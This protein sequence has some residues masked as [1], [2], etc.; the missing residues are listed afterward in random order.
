MPNPQRITSDWVVT[1]LPAGKG[2]EGFDLSPN[3][4]ELWVA[5]AQDG[6]VS[7]IDPIGRKLLETVTVPLKSTNRLKFTLDGARVVMSDLRSN[8]VLVL[9]A[10]TRKEITRIDM[11]ADA[12]MMAGTLM[13]PDGSRVFVSVGS[14]NAVAVIDLK[15][16]AI[17][18][19]IQSG[20][21]PDGLAWAVQK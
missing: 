16:L 12:T 4:K 6:T 15:T 1:T 3:G 17:S 9:D 8:L 20:P 21:G 2:A 11:G 7:I 13:D 14:K 18:G 5:N 10:A 19:W